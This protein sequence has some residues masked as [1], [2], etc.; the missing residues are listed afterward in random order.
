[1]SCVFFM[2]IW[3]KAYIWLQE[4][5]VVFLI[6]LALNLQ[7]TVKRIL[8]IMLSLPISECS[9]SHHLCES[10]YAV[11][12]PEYLCLLWLPLSKFSNFQI[13]SRAFSTRF[14][15][16][17]LIFFESTY[18]VLF[19]KYWFPHAHYLCLEMW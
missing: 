12:K 17:Y 9:R 16:K 15:Y 13:R 4:Y 1:M 11:I 10:S 18:T 2:Y 19:F 14:M 8:F 3:E 6:R 5:L 7:I